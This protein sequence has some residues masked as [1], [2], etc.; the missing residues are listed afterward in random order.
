MRPAGTQNA[1]LA[2]CPQIDKIAFSAACSNALVNGFSGGGVQEEKPI[3]L[4]AV[5]VMPAVE[6]KHLGE[7]VGDGVEGALYTLAVQPIVFDETQDR[8][9]VGREMVDEIVLGEG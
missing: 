8:R 9:L 1:R 5:S 3:I 7:R 4:V 2:G 6:V